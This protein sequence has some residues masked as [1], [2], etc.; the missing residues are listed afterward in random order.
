SFTFNFSSANGSGYLSNLYMLFNG[1][2]SGV[3][4][5][6][7]FW[8]K[9]NG[10]SLANDAGNGL[11]GPMAAG[12]NTTLQNSQCTLS[13]VGS[14]VAGAGNTLSITLNLSF[15]AAFGG[16]KSIF[17]YAVDNGGMNSGWQN[18]GS[19]TVPAIATPPS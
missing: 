2:L 5:C 6:W 9:Y 1:S 13:G 18:R 4:A 7:V 17:M 3:G 11:L 14:T 15:G 12:A 10:L 19:W 16:T 8:D